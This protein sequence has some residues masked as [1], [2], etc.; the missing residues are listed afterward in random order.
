[1]KRFAKLTLVSLILLTGF[2]LLRGT[3]PQVATGTW[4]SGSEMSEARTGAAAVTL[5]DGRVLVFGGTTSSGGATNAVQVFSDGSWSDLGAVMLDARS[6]HSATLLKDGR[7]LLAGGENSSGPL[8]SLEIYDPSSNSFASAASLSG[9]RKSH[10]AARLPD[11]RVL[12]IGGSDGADPS[13]ALASSEI[14][15]P[16]SASVSA[17]PSLGAPRTGLSVTR[18]LDGKILIAGGNNGEADLASTL[19][20]NPADGSLSAGTSLSVP[21]TGHSAILLPYNNSVLISGGSGLAS[22]ELYVPWTSSVSATGSM[23]AARSGAAG[24]GTAWD[25]VVVVAGGSGSASSEL[26]G[27]ATVKTDADDYAPGTIVFITG[28]GWQP[29]ETVTLVLHEIAD[30]HGDLTLTA[31][32]DAF[33]NIANSEYAPEEHDIGVRFYLTAVGASSQAQTTFTDAELLTAEIVGT[34]NDVTVTQGSNT[35]FDIRLSAAGAIL[36]T[37]TSGNP[38]TAKVNTVYSINA[39]GVLSSSTLS[40]AQNFFAGAPLGGPNCSVTWTGA[41][42]PYTVPA[43]V[44]AAATTPVG[45]YTITLS[46]TAGTTAITNPNATGAK[47]ADDTQ[48]LITVHVVAPTNTPPVL[49]LPADITTEAT[50]AAGAVVNFSATATDAEDNPDPT[51]VCVPASGSTFPLGPTQVDCSVTDSGGLS[52]SGSFNVTVQDTTP[53]TIDPHADVTEEATSAAGAIVNY[54]SPATHD[55]VDGDGVASCLP[56]SGSQFALGD[57]TVTCTASDAAG[58]PAAATTFKVTVQDTTP[59][60][61]SILTNPGNPTNSTSAT[62][63][64]TGSD[65]VTAAGDLTFECELDGASF[66]SCSS[67]QNYPGPLDEGSHTFKVRAQ[68]AAGYTDAT[69]AEFTW[70]VD[71]TPPTVNVSFASPV[72]GSG[73]WF[74]AQDSVPVSGSVTASD[75]STV[76]AISCLIDVPTLTLGA[77]VDGNTA[78]ASRTLSV[79]GQGV[80]N[81][82]CTATD[83]A[84]NTGAA[85]P[86][87]SNTA[88]V[89]I[90]TLAPDLQQV[91]TGGFQQPITFITFITANRHEFDYGAQDGGSGIDPNT[92]MVVIEGPGSN[93]VTFPCSDGLT[94]TLEGKLTNPPDGAYTAQISASDLAGNHN[95]GQPFPVTLDNTGPTSSVVHLN[96]PI[97]GSFVTS[98]TFFRG[99]CASDGT[100]VGCDPT[101]VLAYDNGSGSFSGFGAT[102]DF[103]IPLLGDGAKTLRVKTKDLLGNEGPDATLNVTLDNTGPTSSVA[104]H[105]GPVFGSFVSS[106]TVLRGACSNDGAGVGCDSPPSMFLAYDNG[107]GLFSAFGATTDFSIPNSV[108]DGAVTVKAKTK[109]LLGNIGA[110]AM[111]M[112]TLDNT[113]PTVNV[114]GVLEGGI[115]TLG[116]V[117]AAGC[118]TTDPGGSGVATNATVLVAGGVPPGVGSF[119]ATCSGAVDNVGNPQAAPVVV[120]YTVQFAG[121][122]ACLAGPGHQVLQP[123]ELTGSSTFPKKQGR[124]IPVKFRVCDANG[125]SIGPTPVVTSFFLTGVGT[126]TPSPVPNED[127]ESTTP[128]TTFRWDGEKWMFNLST[129]NLFAGYTYQYTITLTDGSTIVFQFGMK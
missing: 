25:G 119:T 12:M 17:G 90:D 129:K 19:I 57:T 2:V 62:F 50:S 94:F 9:A 89:K 128:D 83:A 18:L 24:S 87:S 4:Q 126:G 27:F 33:G 42:T 113:G 104:Y 107:S 58:N 16:E 29:G 43:S 38:A 101:P 122:G 13:S 98:S 3:A 72:F 75:P 56:A 117:P 31:V 116:A 91:L 49:N 86:G 64:F 15:D 44:S 105:S 40:A 79:S 73:G 111:L 8:S 69:P 92:C 6:G 52:D 76:T 112:V 5:D 59:P 109:D 80:H 51:P 96:G 11:G 53:P 23:S 35:S 93:D 63:T 36:C 124:T 26:Y 21:R 81:I 1:M 74:N 70:I 47:L 68:D 77:L 32:A 65:A 28:S 67:P 55:L 84:G 123:I 106:S 127:P 103:S 120:N 100:G 110:D 125:V 88:T 85:S 7:I 71:T 78:N 10:G 121:P 37:T 45:A 39:A 115:Y 61:T 114:T 95:P 14:Y 60:D 20:Y 34:N 97:V 41:A 108:A 46:T 118:S 22:A 99:A 48:T 82:S 102:T 66:Q 54:T 30:F